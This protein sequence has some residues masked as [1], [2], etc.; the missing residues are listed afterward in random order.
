MT[1]EQ[2]KKEQAK[3]DTMD[4][5]EYAKDLSISEEEFKALVKF[6]IYTMDKTLNELMSAGEYWYLSL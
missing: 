5:K 6:S 2:I 1:N 3:V 4:F